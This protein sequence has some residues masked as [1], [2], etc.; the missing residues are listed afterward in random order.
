MHT[1]PLKRKIR[2]FL[3]QSLEREKLV[4]FYYSPFKE[5]NSSVF[6]TVPLKRKIRLF[7]LRAGTENTPMIVGLG[8]AAQLVNTYLGRKLY[9]KQIKLIYTETLKSHNSKA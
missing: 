4:C 6:A 7:L 3:L 5:E 1:V 2:L 9:F 8:E